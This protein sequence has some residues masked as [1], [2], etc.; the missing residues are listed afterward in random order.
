MPEK[1][2]NK[3][4]SDFHRRRIA[5]VILEKGILTAENGFS[6][7][8]FDLLCRSGFS[9]KQARRL[10]AERPRGYAL[11]GNVY[12]YQGTAFSCL[13][14]ENG[15]RAE[16]YVPFFKNNRWLSETGKIYDGMY[17]GEKGTIWC[18]IKEFKISL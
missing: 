5:F 11:N 18:P 4:E 13:S 15:K 6:G 8:H 3:A 7:S 2:K 10:I 12:L 16:Q 1:P 9:E 17:A 14:D